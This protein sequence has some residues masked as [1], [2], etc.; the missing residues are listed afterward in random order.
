MGEDRGTMVRER[1]AP[2]QQQ[3]AAWRR[4]ATGASKMPEEF[5]SRAVEYAREHGTEVV[6][7]ALQLDHGMLRRRLLASAKASTAEAP[8]SGFI[9]LSGAQLFSALPP[10]R[11]S[12]IEFCRRDGA[13]MLVHISDEGAVDVLSLAAMF[14][15]GSV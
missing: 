11:R 14:L 12:T 10:A 15:E 1:M 13:R 2:F 9:E 8:L 5:W 6:A 3:M 4:Q 7:Q